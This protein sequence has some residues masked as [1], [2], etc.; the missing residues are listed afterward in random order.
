LPIRTSQVRSKLCALFVFPRLNH[1][2]MMHVDD[3][4]NSFDRMTH[5]ANCRNLNCDFRAT[6]A[7]LVACRTKLEPLY[8]PTRDRLK[9]SNDMNS[10]ALTTWEEFAV[11]VGISESMLFEKWKRENQCCYPGCTM[12][13]TQTAPGDM[14]QCAGCKSV[15][16]HGK[17][18]QRA[19]VV[20]EHNDQLTLF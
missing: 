2:C 14:K 15:Y 12:R 20:L 17:S 18:C 1:F 6:P 13:D 5:S 8:I 19:Y 4:I 3:W 16:Y 7:Y 10:K 11:A 9:Q